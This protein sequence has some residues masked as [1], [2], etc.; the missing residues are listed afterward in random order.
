MSPPRFTTYD[1]IV[2]GAG[3]A[4][5][6]LSYLLARTGRRVALIDKQRFP[7]DKVCGG[8]VSRKAIALLD[9]DIAPVVH[10]WITAAFLTFKN[11]SAV[12]KDLHSVAGCTVLRDEFDQLLLTRAVEAGA[13]FFDAATF[14][15][16]HAHRAGVTARTSRGEFTGRRLFAA[17][18]VG[19]TVRTK[20]FGSRLVSYVP[21]LEAFVE[22]SNASLQSFSDRAVFDFG[23]MPKGYGWIFPKRDHLNV[24]IYSP[25]RG[26]A[27][28][29]HLSGF[30]DR[31]PALRCH[32]G[33][34]YRGY[35]IPVR[36]KTGVFERGPVALIGDAAGLAESVFGEGIYFALKSA[37]LAAQAEF[38]RDSG[39]NSVQYTQLLRRELIPELR[40]AKL[41]AR[42][43][44]TFQEFTFR[45]AVCN[46]RINEC[47]A[48]LITGDMG[49]RECLRKAILAA[50]MWISRSAPS[51]NVAIA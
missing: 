24:G 31:Y 1:A 16:L 39:A 49:Y 29:Q 25:F 15:E 44:F 19:S 18:G 10:H 21:V 51:S 40:A 12:F 33:I 34:Q 14:F 41:L 36:N 42:G 38:T 37:A 7:R 32:R 11:R 22:V 30:I 45:H 9:V 17:D 27:L 20:V 28:R 3:P 46:D 43:L 35:A 13:H 5:S 6:H 23:G 50:P 47:F 8:G 2:V 4:G 48:G 26:G